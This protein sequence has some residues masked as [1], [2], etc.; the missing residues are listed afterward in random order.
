MAASVSGGEC[1][2]CVHAH[3]GEH[4]VGGAKLIAGVGPA[5]APAEPSAVVEMG[6]RETAP[7][8]ALAAAFR[9]RGAGRDQCGGAAVPA[10]PGGKQSPVA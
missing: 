8:E 7:P 1:R 10:L 2:E 3:R 5:I 9:V 6:A 4:L